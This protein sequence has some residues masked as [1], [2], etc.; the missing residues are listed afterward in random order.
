MKCKDRFEE[1]VDMPYEVNMQPPVFND[2]TASGAGA[3]YFAIVLR[4]TKTRKQT[5]CNYKVK[6]LVNSTISVKIPRGAGKVKYNNIG[7]DPSSY[8][9]SIRLYQ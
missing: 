2:D 7:K 3:E 4:T 6:L 1:K 8:V 9:A 5:V